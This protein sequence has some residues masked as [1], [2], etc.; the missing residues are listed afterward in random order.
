MRNYLFIFSILFLFS[1]S[2][3]FDSKSKTRK[4]PMSKINTSTASTPP[5]AVGKPAN[6]S[7][8]RLGLGTTSYENQFTKINVLELNLNYNLKYFVNQSIY[9]KL[10]PAAHLHSG[11]VQSVDG[12]ESL[13]NRLSVQHAAAYFQWMKESYVSAGIFNQHEVFSMLLVSDQMAF[14]AGQAKQSISS[15]PWTFGVLGQTAIPNSRSAISDQHEKES[16]P[17]LTSVGLT[18]R[19]ETGDKN[20]VHAKANYFKFSQLPTSVSTASVVAGNTSADTRISDTERAFKY[21]YQ[22]LDSDLTFRRRIYKAAYLLGA[23]SFLENQG[24]PKGVNQAYRAGGGAGYTALGNHDFEISGY[25]YRIESDASVGAYS[26]PDYFAT[27]HM[28]YEFIAS[29]KNVKQNFR[30]TFSY[31]DAKLIVENPAQSD[32]KKYFLSFEVLNVAL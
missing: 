10:N 14:M 31:C 15:G 29:W 7:S 18:S 13:E 21:E 3:G 27:N 4:E 20:R 5:G 2:W 22:G 32:E 9:L 1:A 6:E 23:G 17:M 16:S 11:T 30:V 24:A 26:N 25:T 12:A 8:L 28:G 19:W